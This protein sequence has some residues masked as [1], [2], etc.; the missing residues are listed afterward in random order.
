MIVTDLKHVQKAVSKRAEDITRHFL[1][2][3][4]VL[5]GFVSLLFAAMPEIALILSRFFLEPEAGFELNKNSFLIA[6]RDVNKHDPAN[7]VQRVTLP[8]LQSLIG[9]AS[10]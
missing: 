2:Q 7:F 1:P 8:T 9:K 6:F 5:L 4:L 3:A 10:L